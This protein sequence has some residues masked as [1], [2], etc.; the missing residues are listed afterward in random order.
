MYL[1][2]KVFP[3]I[4]VSIIV[5]SCSSLSSDQERLEVVTVAQ[6]EVFISE[7]GYVTDAERFGWSIVQQDLFNFRKV[8]GATWRTP[9][10]LNPSFSKALPVTQ[11]SYN[12]AMAYCQWAG[13]R[14]PTYDEYWEFVKHDQRPVVS[15]SSL[16]ISPPSEVNTVGN[17]WEITSSRSGNEVRLAGGSIY[18]SPTIC[19]GT[20]KGREFYVD[21]QTGNIHI[22]FAV[23]RDR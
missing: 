3:I 22:G 17:V 14:L 13:A 15:E 2:N 12:D 16:P 19:N 8:R 18:C 6:F 5:V 20:S 1:F 23:I 7:T 21:T 9:D 10:G 11:V 4:Y